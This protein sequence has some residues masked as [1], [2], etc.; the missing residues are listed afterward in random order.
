MDTNND[1]QG[2]DLSEAIL[3]SI[4]DNNQLKL[5]HLGQPFHCSSRVPFHSLEGAIQCLQTK[6]SLLLL[7]LPLLTKAQVCN[8]TILT[9][10]WHLIQMCPLPTDLQKQVNCVLHPFL[11]LGCCNWICHNYV[12]APCHLGG[13]DVINSEQMAMTILGQIVSCLLCNKDPI[14]F[15]F[16]AA[17]Q[18]HLWDKYKVTLAHFILH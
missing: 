12:T 1:K 5:M 13:L 8:S 4:L 3:F 9:K 2:K 17:L 16:C 11:F 18:Q 15:Q 7:S 6:I 14:G 10:F